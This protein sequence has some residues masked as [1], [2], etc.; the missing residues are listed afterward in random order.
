M[1]PTPSYYSRTSKRHGNRMD[2]K[3]AVFPIEHAAPLTILQE[4]FTI[5]VLSHVSLY[6][7]VGLEREEEEEEGE[8]D[9]KEAEL[10]VIK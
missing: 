1:H 9:V 5:T 6:Q 10:E 7:L 3:K 2:E 4:Q 8:D